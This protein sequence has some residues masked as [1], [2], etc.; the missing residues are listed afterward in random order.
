MKKLILTI[1]MLLMLIPSLCFAVEPVI[2]SD[3]R[4]F[5]PLKGIYDLQGHVFVQFPAHDTTLTITGDT[6][7]V[8]L[9]QMEVHG[10]GNITL[11]FGEMRFKCD[12]VDVYHADRTVYVA[13]NGDF[14][15]EGMLATADKG[16]YC[17]KTKLASFQGNVKVN[18]KAQKGDVVYN[19]MTKKLVETA[20]ASDTQQN[21]KIKLEASSKANKKK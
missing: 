21:A 3:S 20:P 18:G 10:Q 8:H 9:Y 13:G 4:T 12:R 6:T 1:A 2:K 16:S 14:K 19:V 11:S 17:W 5:N 15:D 7:K